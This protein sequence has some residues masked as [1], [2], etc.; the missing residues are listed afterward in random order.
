[1]TDPIRI[2]IPHQL[3]RE[4]ARERIARGIGK[5]AD[6]VPGGAVTEHQWDGD[7]LSF[8]VEAMG[9]RVVSRLDVLDTSVHAEFD[10]P[11]MLALFAGRIRDKLAREA[12]KLLE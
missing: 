11:P 2:D 1:M 8:A 4:A 9:Q 3:G 6:L 12:P 10:L 7:R 5:L